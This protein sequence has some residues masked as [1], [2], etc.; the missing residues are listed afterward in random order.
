MTALYSCL[1]TWMIDAWLFWIGEDLAAS[2]VDTF[3]RHGD[4]VLGSS[5][6]NRYEEL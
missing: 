2:F 3:G 6:E 5:L 1:L 4:S